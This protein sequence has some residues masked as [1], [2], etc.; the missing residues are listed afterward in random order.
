MVNPVLAS[1]PVNA[2]S[3]NGTNTTS[4]A[5]TNTQASAGKGTFPQDT[6]TI[7]QSAIQAQ[8]ASTGSTKP[9][10]GDAEHDGDKS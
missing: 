9:D 6:V 7:S 1:N 4:A 5:N 3:Q 10:S 2:A 8:A